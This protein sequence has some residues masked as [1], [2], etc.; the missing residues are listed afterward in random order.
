MLKVKFT[1]SAI[2]KWL[3]LDRNEPIDQR[4]CNSP[5]GMMRLTDNELLL[6]VMLE[7]KCI[8]KI[9]TP[10]TPFGVTILF[11]A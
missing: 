1:H 8:L 3:V 6:A 10:Q 4:F 7:R 5:L 9:E 11:S 2:H